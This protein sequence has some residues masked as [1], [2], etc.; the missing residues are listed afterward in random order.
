[1]SCHVCYKTVGIIKFSTQKKIGIF[2][3]V[4]WMYK[5]VKY[6]NPFNFNNDNLPTFV[7]LGVHLVL[8]LKHAICP[9]PMY[10]PFKLI[11]Y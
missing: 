3:N 9:I 4:K 10:S 5:R 2:Y 11:E 6:M 7:N 1:M 8:I